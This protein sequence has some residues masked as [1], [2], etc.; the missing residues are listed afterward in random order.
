MAYN[1]LK[2]KVDGSV[3]Q[4][5]DQEIGGVKVFKSTISASVFYD[6]DAQA[7]CVTVKD[8][9]VKKIAGASRNGILT[10]QGD[11]ELR[12][13]HGLTYDGETL[14]VHKVK[15]KYLVG[16]AV[17]MSDIPA[18]KF[19]EKINAESINFGRGLHN[20]RKEIQV[21]VINGLE[22]DQDGVGI[23]LSPTSG[24]SIRSKNLVVDPIKT[25]AIN[26][27]G[28]NLSDQDLLIVSDVSK[29]TTNSTTLKN[30]Y[31]NYISFKMPRPSGNKNEIQ[32]MGSNEF[33]STSNLSYDRQSNTLSV[34]GRI[35][36]QNLKISS[37]VMC[38]GAVHH[39][40]NIISDPVYH[41]GPEDYTILCDSIKNKIKVVLPPAV[42]NDGRV[43]IIKKANANRLKLNSNTVEIHCEEGTIDINNTE[44]LKMN[45]SSRTL[46]S[47]GENWWII[48]TKGS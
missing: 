33:E 46:Q 1:V 36:T 14:Q 10:Y 28:Q 26:M 39:N 31:D 37:A 41:V 43:L 3:D 45:Y 6:T 16:S 13:H 12:A 25:E 7:P 17:H 5:G 40:I 22:V 18:N 9:A 8:L 24:L 20:V 27:R 11:A 2:G 30:L 21:K 23:S 19:H 35:K 47:N 48:G 44:T 15:A 34:D 29:G 32:F 42:N 38:G 4:Y